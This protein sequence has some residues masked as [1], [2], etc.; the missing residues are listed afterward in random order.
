MRDAIAL[1]ATRLEMYRRRVFQRCRKRQEL[2]KTHMRLA[3]ITN[4]PLRQWWR[5]RR[6]RCYA[7]R[8]L[9]T[10]FI[11]ETSRGVRDLRMPTIRWKTDYGPCYTGELI[12]S[13]TSFLSNLCSLRVHQSCIHPRL[14]GPTPRK[15]SS[16]LHVYNVTHSLAAGADTD[17]GKQ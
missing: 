9:E 8:V 13:Q 6:F 12:S 2:R 17:S 3:P 7:R 4:R 10:D 11:A 14:F 5:G 1:S 15:W 16:S